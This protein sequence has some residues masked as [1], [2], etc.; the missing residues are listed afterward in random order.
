[1][2]RGRS[3]EVDLNRCLP[4]AL[5]R[6]S[7]MDLAEANTDVFECST[8]GNVG[9]GDGDGD[10]VCCDGSMQP[11]EPDRDG[12]IEA[13][14]LEEL[15][16]TV[17]DMSDTELEI[18]LCVMETGH[19]TVQELAEATDYDRSNVSRHLNHLVELGV[20]RK[21]R[22]LLKQGGHEY[23]YSPMDAD[24]VRESLK[25]RFVRWVSKAAGELDAVRREKVEGIVEDASPDTKTLVYREE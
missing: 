21:R 5:T 9:V 17:F 22:R 11:V 4:Y 13:P 8:C 3:W 6:S 18:C 1:M 7:Y 16:R 25:R 2:Q 19:Q 20:V 24:A 15:L 23:V 14:T 10:I 12:G